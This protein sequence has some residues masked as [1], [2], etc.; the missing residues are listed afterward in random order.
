MEKIKQESPRAYEPWTT[1]EETQLTQLY[2]ENKTIQEIATT[3]QRQ[4]GGINSRLK[5]IGLIN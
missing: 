5:K 1:Q 3:L 2:N 4:K